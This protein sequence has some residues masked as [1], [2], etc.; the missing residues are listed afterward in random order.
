MS[1]D[2]TNRDEQSNTEKKPSKLLG[3]LRIPLLIIAGLAFFGL[4]VVGVMLGDLLG[5]MIGGALGLGTAATVAEA[6]S[7]AA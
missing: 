4:L 2:E 1:N 7:S 5:G 3:T 6:A